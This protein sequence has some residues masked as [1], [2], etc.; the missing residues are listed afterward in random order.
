[1]TKPDH[2]L[3]VD[4]DPEIRQLLSTYLTE[5]GYRTSV[6]AEGRE[7]RRRLD[8]LRVDLVVLDLM[9]PGED[10]L[11]LCRDL[12]A[13]SNIPVIMLTAR[14]TLVD[15]IVGLE[16]GA[17][18]YLAKPFDP[19]ELLARIKVVLRRTQSFPERARVDDTRCLRFAGWRLD[20]ATRQLRSPA[21]LV[22]SLGN[23]DYRLLRLLLQHPNRALSRD[24]LL[25]HVFDR[26]REPFDRSIDVCVSRVRQHLGD[27]PRNPALIRTVRNEG[28]MLTVDD[29]SSE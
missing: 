28:Y 13:R 16:M 3:I 18:D 19:R 10:G 26:E 8:E 2:I 17:D 7:M 24:F 22:I 23:S 11:S 1:M 27:A 6:A 14:G 21:G 15:R 20:T 5:A 25:N 29:V 4:D 12:R 9:L